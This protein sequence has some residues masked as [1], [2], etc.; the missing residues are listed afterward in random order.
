MI[1]QKAVWP[2]GLIDL[3]YFA[4]HNKEK[5]HKSIKF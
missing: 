1:N 4:I 3:Q 5:L 2:D